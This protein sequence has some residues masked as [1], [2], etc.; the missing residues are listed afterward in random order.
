MSKP[1]L[2]EPEYFECNGLWLYRMLC[3]GCDACEQTDDLEVERLLMNEKPDREEM[4]R[5]VRAGD[6]SLCCDKFT[7]PYFAPC[8]IEFGL[9]VLETQERDAQ[10]EALPEM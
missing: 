8:P 1:E 6:H 7:E 5:R 9:A 2:H 10:A 4:I 3:G